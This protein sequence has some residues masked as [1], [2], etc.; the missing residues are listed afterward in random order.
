MTMTRRESLK[1]LALGA[2]A[3]F[4]L[5]A[6]ELLA[7]HE[8]SAQQAA[9]PAP[10]G[11]FVLPPLGYAF[12]ALEPHIDAQTMQ[13]HHDKHH[14]TY[15]TKLNEAVASHADL[16]KLPV[17]QLL[18]HLNKVPA[19]VRTAVQNHG[20]GHFN[21]S[22]FWPV[23]KKDSARTPSGELAKAID[24]KFNTF[25]AFQDQFN[26]AALGVFGSGWVWLVSDHAGVVSIVP[27]PNQD[28]PVTQGLKPLLGIDVWEHA[29]YL[30]YQ[31]RRADYVTAFAKIVDWDVV[32][33][34]Y[35]QAIEK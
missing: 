21:H 27:K 17:E 7:P 12:D 6:G 32:S 18:A 26:K 25:D 20:G 16:Q 30:L 19:A 31:N 33:A 5:P 34:R 28:S 23:L 9:P 10:G 8:A 35:R 13:I 3:L 4:T 24:R 29:Y 22:L 1:T 15:V 11:P 2:S 14:A